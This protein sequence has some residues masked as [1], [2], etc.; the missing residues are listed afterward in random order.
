MKSSYRVLSRLALM[1]G[2]GVVQ[3]V[4]CSSHTKD[5]S[6][7]EV[8]SGS[9]RLPL[10]ATAASGNV[11]RL[12][13]AFFEIRNN[14]TG[15]SVAVISS[16]D[17]PNSAL[18]TRVLETGDYNINLFPG[19][20]LERLISNGSGGAG[21]FGGKG[22]GGGFNPGGGSSG[23]VSAGGSLARGGR[24]GKGTGGAS[25]G[26]FGE[27][28]D[29][30]SA[31]A[32][33]VIGGVGG[34][35]DPGTGG[36][37]S[38]FGGFPFEGGAP[39]TGGIPGKGGGGTI[40]VSVDAQLISNATQF[41]NV[42]SRSDSFVF[43]TFQIGGEVIDFNQGR[44][45]IGI[46]VIEVVPPCDTPPGVTRPERVL[47]E[48]D[49]AAVGNI[50][51]LDVFNALANN[52]GFAGDGLRMY[53]QLFDSYA[54]AANGQIPEA[55]HCGD[56]T[57]NG[58]PTLNGFPINCNRRERFHVNDIENF[59]AT[60]IVNRFDL[61]PANG[62]NCGQQR[63]V[64]ANGSGGRTFMIVEAVIPNP[65][66][67]LGLQAC[68]P[69]AD[70][71]FSQNEIESPFERGD[72][73][74]QAFLVGHPDL[75]AAGFGP[76]YTA[77][78]LTVG[79]GQLRTNQFDDSPW[80]LR[81]FKIAL[82]G[83]SL[84]VIPFPT[85]ESPNGFLWDDTLETPQGAACREN[86]LSAMEGLMTDDMNQMSFVVDQACRNSESQNDGFTEDYAARTSPG[87]A[88]TIADGLV[89]TGLTAKDIGNRARF[90]GSCIGCHMEASSSSLGRGVQAPVSFDFPHIQESTTSCGSGN[91]GGAC[92]SL[93]VALT[94]VF[95]PSR[96][97]TLANALQ[98]PIVTDP[99]TGSGG[100]GFGGRGGFPTTSGGRF[101]RTGTAT[102][103][104]GST[105]TG[106]GTGIDLDG[107]PA[108]EVV[109]EL[110]QASEPLSD[111]VQQDAEIRLLSGSKTISGRSAQS[112]H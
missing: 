4:A 66:P 32:A 91:P 111:L 19:W 73:L 40:G 75:L 79:S 108:P 47:L 13:N 30:G 86:F 104:G 88:N 54:D 101:G 28:G 16:E 80:T 43:Y 84:K 83:N 74:A 33:E 9:L 18:L 7:D 92:F 36:F 67:E 90:A 68:L 25:G 3:L 55:V 109:I 78:N 62:A 103:S 48:N 42:F 94:D 52:D 71:W 26:F 97:N 98:V 39:G 2:V 12:R 58:L 76:F 10:Q 37:D 87:F 77:T 69:L 1:V 23:A 60:A 99:C 50:R 22:V 110:P 14:R 81:E 89:G 31:G 45:N 38:G 105:G 82:D 112:T 21:G 70:F 46:D 100:G 65:A 96:L 93:S 8:S 59:F 44:L 51:L 5:N 107:G 27:G 34:S 29:V 64:F 20:T 24:P 102:G 6:A 11:Y 85:A 61:A 56:E 57:T 35:F 72:R 17:D 15:E 41:F 49:A 63:M 95:L 106:T 53:Q